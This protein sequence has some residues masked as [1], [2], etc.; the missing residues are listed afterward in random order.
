MLPGS[1][2]M[3]VADRDRTDPVATG[4]GPA[5]H[6]P[7]RS[8]C[9]HPTRSGRS[10]GRKLPGDGESCGLPYF[11]VT[12]VPRS[13]ASVKPV[14]VLVL[15]RR[16]VHVAIRLAGIGSP[17]FPVL[18][19]SGYT[20][21]E[22]V[23]RRSRCRRRPSYC[24]RDRRSDPATC[25]ECPN[26]FRQSLAFAGSG[27]RDRHRPDALRG[28]ANRRRRT[29][30]AAD[31]PPHVSDRHRHGRRSCPRTGSPGRPETSRRS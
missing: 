17:G 20:E 19:S 13:F 24:S 16:G 8:T 29:A 22:I 5:V 31:C 12:F 23:V 7:R 28:Q 18:T 4:D 10:I 2:W 27:P 11:N 21:I 14:P 25:R 26:G 15:L 6:Q 1:V 30:P 9:R 3:G